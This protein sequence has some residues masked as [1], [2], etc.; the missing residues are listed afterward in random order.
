M[1]LVLD[2]GAIIALLYQKDPHHR[3]CVALVDTTHEDL[4]VPAPVLVELDYW[5]CKHLGMEAWERFIHDVAEGAYGL[6]DLDEQDLLRAAEIQRRYSNLDLGFVDAAVVTVCE[7][8][9]EKKVITIDRRHFSIIKPRHCERLQ[10]L[11]E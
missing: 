3:A 7:R 9:G 10:I 2:T 6:V 8:L 11:P 5:V 4:L 1:A